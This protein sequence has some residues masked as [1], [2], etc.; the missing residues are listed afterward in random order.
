MITTPESC[1]YYTATISTS[2]DHP[3]CGTLPFCEVV[4][5]GPHTHTFLDHNSIHQSRGSCVVSKAVSEVV[6]DAVDWAMQAPLR[7]HF[8][9]LPEADMKEILHKRMWETESYKTHKDHTQLFEALEKSMNHDHSEELAQDLAEACKKKKK[10][11]ESAHL[12]THL[13]LLHQQDHPELQELLELS[14]HP[15]CHH[16]HLHLHPPI[17]K[18][19]PK[20]PLHQAHHR[21]LPQLNIK[22]GRRLTSDSGQERPA[23]SELAWLIPSSDVPVPPNNW[24]SALASNYSPLL[25]DSL[26]TQTDDMAIFIDWFCKR[27]AHHHLNPI[28]V[29]KDNSPRR[30]DDGV[31]ILLLKARG[32][33]LRFGEVQLSLVTL[34]P[35][36]EVF[37]ALSDN[38]LSGP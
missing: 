32:R 9:D 37:Y 3:C 19:R 18:V 6:T 12:I 15:K 23:T 33:P 14:D 5:L 8:R 16:H 17:K 10:S 24:A 28:F 30:L 1:L 22:P 26:L 13:L 25:E 36:L 35:K 21:Q 38:Q 7:N 11:R 20:A 27:R 34:N 4:T 31:V 2:L 29:P